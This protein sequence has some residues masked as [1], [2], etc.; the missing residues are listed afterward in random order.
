[1]LESNVS[2]KKDILEILKLQIQNLKDIFNND[3]K[4]DSDTQYLLNSILCHCLL[5]VCSDSIDGDSVQTE[6]QYLV[7]KQSLEQNCQLIEM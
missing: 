5:F 2:S 4:E 6:L 7:N 3:L 1:M